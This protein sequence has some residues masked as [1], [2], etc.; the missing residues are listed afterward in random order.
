M[1][2][3]RAQKSKRRMEVINVKIEKKQ[4]LFGFG[5]TKALNLNGKT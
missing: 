4:L 2:A 1:H 3:K 5:V